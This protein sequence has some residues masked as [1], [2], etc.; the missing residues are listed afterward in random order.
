MDSDL[1]KGGGRIHNYSP[2]GLY[3]EIATFLVCSDKSGDNLNREDRR[4]RRVGNN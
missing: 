2:E 4:T 1:I 3:Q